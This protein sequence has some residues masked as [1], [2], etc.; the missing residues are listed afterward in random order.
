MSV[1]AVGAADVILGTQVNAYARGDGFLARVEMDETGDIALH[2]FG[3]DALFELADGL[4][5]LVGF[6]YRFLI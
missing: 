5:Q 1:S 4:H 6:K 3:V 2:E